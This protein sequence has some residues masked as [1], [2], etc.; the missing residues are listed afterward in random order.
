MTQAITNIP[1]CCASGG[2]KSAKDRGDLGVSACY[3]L[4]LGQVGMHLS[5][6]WD[7]SLQQEDPTGYHRLPTLSTSSKLV[8]LSPFLSHRQTAWGER[9]HHILSLLPMWIFFLFYSMSCTKF[10]VISHM[11]NTWICYGLH[12][13]VTWNEKQT[14]VQIWIILQYFMMHIPSLWVSIV[15]YFIAIISIASNFSLSASAIHL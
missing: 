6:C 10:V 15:T 13:L 11:S 9:K 2:S 8:L 4:F 7:A 5:C 1:L 12:R 14:A 3:S